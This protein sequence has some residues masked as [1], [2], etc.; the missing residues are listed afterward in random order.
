MIKFLLKIYLIIL[1]GAQLFALGIGVK[2]GWDTGSVAAGFGVFLFAEFW[3]I[4]AAVPLYFVKP[5][6]VW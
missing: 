1:L 4:G 3:A 2:A 5:E 6:S